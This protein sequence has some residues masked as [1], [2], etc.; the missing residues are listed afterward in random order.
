MEEV[1]IDINSV[2]D[3][4]SGDGDGSGE[5]TAQPHAEGSNL[6]PSTSGVGASAS[7]NVATGG[8]IGHP[9]NAAEPVYKA[10]TC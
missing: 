3:S 4:M 9:R 6:E 10:Q 5:A 1:A 7:G 2:R 8:A